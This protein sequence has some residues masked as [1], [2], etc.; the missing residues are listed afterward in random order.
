VAARVEVIDGS[1]HTLFAHYLMEARRVGSQGSCLKALLPGQQRQYECR[2]SPRS[3]QHPLTRSD[4]SNDIRE[5]MDFSVVPVPAA[6]WLFGSALGLMGVVGRK[7]AAAT[8]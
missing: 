7:K 2:E 1:F 8:A 4:G 6:V 3:D 5:E